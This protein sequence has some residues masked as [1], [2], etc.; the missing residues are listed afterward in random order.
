MNTEQLSKVLKYTIQMK[1]S[2]EKE[3]RAYSC[4]YNE[5]SSRLCMRQ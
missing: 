4:T 3:K 5:T 1:K 2:K